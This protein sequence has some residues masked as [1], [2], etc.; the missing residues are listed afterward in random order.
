L[1]ERGCRARAHG[2]PVGVCVVGRDA[3]AGTVRIGAR[4]HMARILVIEDEETVRRSVR[5][6]L[7]REGHAVL[8]AGNGSRGLELLQDS[9]VDL[10]LTDLYMADVDGIEFTI[11]LR[12]RAPEV[13]IIAMSGGGRVGR[14]DVLSLAQRLGATETLAKPFER[15]DLLAVVDRVL[16][17]P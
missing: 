12:E 3:L 9:D 8:E 13:K 10:I 16:G 6:L 11:R 17:L 1:M 14:E 4:G 5:K 2:T 15:V 7:E